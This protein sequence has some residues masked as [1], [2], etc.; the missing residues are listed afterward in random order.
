MTGSLALLCAIVA[1]AAF[2]QGSIGVGFA[3][4]LA[5]VLAI[6]A[7]QL[8]PVCLLALM[9][10][11]NAYVAW[12]E[13]AALDWRGAAWI[14]AAR[15]LGTFGGIAIL[16]SLSPHGLGIV[17]GAV[18]ILASLATLAAPSFQPGPKAF[19][20]AGLVT[21][22]SETATG[23]GGPPLALVYQHH[24]A[25]TLRATLAFCFLA[26]QIVSLALLAFAGH[27]DAAQFLA[28]IELL[29]ALIVGALAS[30]LVHRRVAGGKLRIAVLAFAIVSGAALLFR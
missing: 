14:T 4:I 23:I 17:I 19:L 5:P 26:G 28:A 22:V 15:I 29:P 21:G 24:P 13:R 7:P 20:V 11:L 25:P 12:R 16:A 9:V 30:R 18:T 1:L 10:P 27:A 2:V 6:A 3:M 8:V